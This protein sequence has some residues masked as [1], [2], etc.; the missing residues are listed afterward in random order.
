MRCCQ[1][2]DWE[3]PEIKVWKL[4]LEKNKTDAIF[5]CGRF[6]FSRRETAASG[7]AGGRLRVPK[8]EDGG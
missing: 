5:H 2:E 8:H 6:V 7:V 3:G 1:F 4:Y